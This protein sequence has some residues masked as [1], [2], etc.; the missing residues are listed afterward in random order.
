MSILNNLK[1]IDL[2][3]EKGRL[4]SELLTDMGA[5]VIRIEKPGARVPHTDANSGKRTISLDIETEKGRHLLASM[6][7]GSDVVVESFSPG[8][9]KLLRLGYDEL[10]GLNP[11]LI[12]VSISN[13][14]QT[15]PYR[16]YKSS[17]L[18]ASAL[19]GQAYV[20]GEPDKPPL[21][22][23]GPQAYATA[24][25]FAANGILLA[26]WQ[27]QTTKRGQYIDISVHECV[28]ATLDHVLVRYFYE[29]VVA[30]RLGSLYWNN[31]FRI[32]PCQDG[33]LLL[34]LFQQW[35]T[36]I[37]WL[38]SENMAADLRD[39]KYLN[40]AERLKN[41]D[42][43]IE[44][45]EKWT[46]GHTADEL[47]PLGQLMRFPWARVASIPDILNSPQLNERGFFLEAVDHASGKRYRFPGAPVKIGWF[48]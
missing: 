45:L 20:C 16:E 35:E 22:P 41:L 23:F 44:V 1:V 8:Y 37:A 48:P 19:G 40:E 21:K 43:I 9:L 5:E 33:Y 10:A 38:S 30:K 26:I 29:G 25:L 7:E 15:G 17:D 18:V 4:C 24:C 3:D 34:S 36:L 39:E 28:A 12:M 32:F 11:Q 13:F 6:V 42:H 46:L 27:R 14:G 2:T 31:A 47:V